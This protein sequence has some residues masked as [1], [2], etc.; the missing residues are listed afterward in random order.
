MTKSKKPAP[1]NVRD[2]FNS[3]F[4]PIYPQTPVK[5]F[6]GKYMPVHNQPKV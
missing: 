4:I 3:A 5:K 6:N 1:K 2:S